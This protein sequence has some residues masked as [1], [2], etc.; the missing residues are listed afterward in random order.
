MIP[1]PTIAA[2]KAATDLQALAAE[3]APLR[4]SGQEYLTLCPWHKEKTPSLR[5][6]KNHYYCY[7]CGVSGSAIDWLMQLNQLSFKE[8]VTLLAERAGISLDQKPLS[9]I[10][11]SYALQEAE[12]CQWW[13][14]KYSGIVTTTAQNEE[15]D[16]NEMLDCLG[17]IWDWIQGLTP[18]QKF[19]FF[20]E[21][22]TEDDRREWLAGVEE[23]EAFEAG[24]REFF[25]S[26]SSPFNLRKV[27]EVGNA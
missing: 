19:E 1:A 20:R 10:A 12:F 15:G 9:R 23:A 6:Y 26:E 3:H 2:I 24:V 5:V 18:Q 13:W 8:S 11:Y 17:R 14:Q 21:H 4:K 25:C 16:W 7:G 27:S 22:R